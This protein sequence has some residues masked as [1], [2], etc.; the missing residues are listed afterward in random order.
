MSAANIASY[1][2]DELQAADRRWRTFREQALRIQQI[3]EAAAQSQNTFNI[4]YSNTETLLPSLYNATPRPVVQRRYKDDNVLAK[5]AGR[6]LERALEYHMDTP[7]PTYEPFDAVMEASVLGA[8]VPGLGLAKIR[9]DAD[10]NPLG[11]ITKESQEKAAAIR[12]KGAEDTSGDPA[13]PAEAELVIP[14]EATEVT[15][16]NVCS[17]TVEY[18]RVLF[19]NARTWSKMPWVAFYHAMSRQDATKAFGREIADALS[20]DQPDGR[21]RDAEEDRKRSPANRGLTPVWEIWHR[22]T[23]KVYFISQ[24]Y[25]DGPLKEP[26][27]DPLR[28]QGFFP[29]PEPLVLFSRVGE[30]IPR[31]LYLF[32]ENQAKEL[33]RISTRLNRIIDALKVRGFYAGS[34]PGLSDIM[35][36]EENTI[37]PLQNAGMATDNF[38]LDKYLWLFPLEKL[39]TVLQQ[40]YIQ[41]EQCKR[42][43]YEITGLSDIIRGSTVASETA[44]A[45]SIKSQWGTQRLKKMQKR[46]QRYV[47]DYLRLVS[48]VA[49]KHFGE[50]TWAQMTGVQLPT[51]E[52]K[53]AAQQQMM[54]AP[55][56]QPG[57]PP[58]P[59]DP[60][61]EKILSMPSW[62]EVLPYLQ[63]DMLRNYSI[64]IETNST[65]E[66]EAVEDQEQIAK[67]LGAMSNMFSAIGPAVQQGALPIAGF[68][69]MLI[70]VSRR[71]RFGDEVE[72]VLQQIPDQ[73]PQQGQD[74]GKEAETQ[75]KL[76]LTQAETQGKLQIMQAEVQVKEKEVQIKMQE[77]AL[78][79]QELKLKEEELMQKRQLSQ[80]KAE[81]QITA[82]R[83]KS[84]A[85]LI[86]AQTPPTPKAPQG[87]NP[88]EVPPGAEVPYNAAV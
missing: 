11:M 39:I 67:L 76:Q 58:Q 74:K 21:R 37:S 43:I 26:I 8:L 59:Q 38:S 60:R 84:Q 9:Y 44:T 51:A 29:C 66:P 19:G 4:L 78:K 33:N 13:D 5:L 55:P 6:V 72:D 28:L 81:G 31:P 65:V 86:A 50:R 46:T 71:F 24:D 42:V 7:D 17:E 49:G 27:E 23:K 79:E 82:A 1:W 56:P 2:R 40:L 83:A 12:S 34:I 35:Q 68:K 70:A 36:K 30:F 75:A 20:Y 47:R 18:D 80:I 15:Y 52:E 41:R 87:A 53:A 63:M 10:F 61:A 69:A 77:L 57:Q 3:Y 64:D 25:A 14:P 85:A 16:E 73:M 88:G 62:G 54:Q 45:Q 22:T 48:E 32:Y